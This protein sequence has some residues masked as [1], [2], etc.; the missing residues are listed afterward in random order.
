MDA[1][2][3][4]SDE[5]LLAAYCQGDGHAFERLFRRYQ[6]PLYR[7][8]TRMLN[9]R[10]AAEDVVIETFE[11]LHTHRDRLWRDAAVRPWVY[12]VANNLA[13]NRL[14]RDRL[15]GWLP[16]ATV[17]AVGRSSP[18]AGSQRE[19]HERVAAAFVALPPRQRETCSLR[20]LGEVRA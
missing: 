18:P 11:R 4:A 3:E 1:T 2:D 15:V 9:D 13:R 7:H 8:L 20:L 14:R 19:V 16:L 10:D 17:D 6:T 12:T 5:S